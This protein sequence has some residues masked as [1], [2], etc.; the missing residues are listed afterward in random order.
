[1]V[2]GARGRGDKEMLT[3]SFP[4]CAGFTRGDMDDRF[5]A[6]RGQAVYDALVRALNRNVTVRV[7]QSAG[8]PSEDGRGGSSNPNPESAALARRFPLSFLVKT[9]NM[10][11]WYGDGIQHACHLLFTAAGANL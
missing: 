1:M 7:L 6:Q 4:D 11:S 3:S 8:F 5:L 9:L 2:A 10:S